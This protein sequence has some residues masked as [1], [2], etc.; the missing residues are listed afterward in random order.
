MKHATAM[1]TLLFV[2]IAVFCVAAED[3]VLPAGQTT[4]PVMDGNP[5]DRSLY[6]EYQ[7]KRVYFCCKMC[8]NTFKTSP[9]KY[10]AKLPQFH[11]APALSPQVDG[12]HHV[13][14]CH[15]R[16]QQRRIC[17]SSR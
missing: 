2:A 12:H 3:A 11:V 9:E 17:S 6:A 13:C 1:I 5:I 8:L 10:L 7:E 4:C 14:A 15:Y 16:G